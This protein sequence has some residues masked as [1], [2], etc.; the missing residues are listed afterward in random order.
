MNFRVVYISNSCKLSFKNNN[1]AVTNDK[2]ITLIP[3]NDI[4]VLLIENLASSI[5]SKLLSNL[6]QNKITTIICDE[7]HLPNGILLPY[8]GKIRMLQSYK[9]QTNCTQEFKNNLWDKIIKNKIYNQATILQYTLQ[10]DI[11]KELLSMIDDVKNGDNKNIESYTAQTYWKSI[12][13]QT[14][15]YFTRNMSDVRNSA[16][17]Y[18]YAI[19]RS[20]IANSLSTKGFILYDG[21]HHK[22]ELNQFNFVDD[23]IEPFRVFV[24]MEVYEIFENEGCIKEQLDSELKKR[25]LGIVDNEAHIK[26]QKFTLINAIDKY[27]DSVYNCYKSNDSK[28]LLEVTIDI[29]S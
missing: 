16:L 26:N 4:S 1:L 2:G 5:S 20:I 8:N 28:K 10:D 9:Y 25:L 7:H 11:A 18:G 6:T 22:S 13:A 15:H 19:I 29:W 21:I 27:C 14:F 17:N 12:F 24:D 3:L 23:I